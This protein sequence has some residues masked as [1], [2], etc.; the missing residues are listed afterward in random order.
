MLGFMARS[1]GIMHFAVGADKVIYNFTQAT[2]NIWMIR[3][4]S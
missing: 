1:E 4:G 2:G 3:R